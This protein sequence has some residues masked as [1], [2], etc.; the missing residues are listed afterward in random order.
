MQDQVHRD[1]AQAFTASSIAWTVVALAA[2]VAIAIY[3]G[4]Q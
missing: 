3:M 4:M 2:V 1:Q